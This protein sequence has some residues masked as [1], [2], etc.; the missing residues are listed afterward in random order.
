MRDVAV[1]LGS[2]LV[3][4]ILVAFA[5]A[6]PSAK[7]TVAVGPAVPRPATSAFVLGRILQVDGSGLEGAT[8]E[9]RRS[10]R[11]AGKTLSDDAGAFRVALRGG[12]SVYAISL[13]AKAQGSTVGTVSRRRLC[14]G[15]ALPIDARVVTQGHFLW[16]PGPR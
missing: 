2:A 14:P 3:V 13:H 15:D 9:V 1:A 8:I 4:A 5:L 11:L 12:C 7:L 10:G 6:G 16:V